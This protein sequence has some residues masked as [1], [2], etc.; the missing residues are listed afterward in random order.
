MSNE[1]R[2]VIF[3]MHLKTLHFFC[4]SESVFYAK[5]LHKAVKMKTVPSVIAM[6]NFPFWLQQDLCSIYQFWKQPASTSCSLIFAVKENS[7]IHSRFHTNFLCT[8]LTKTKQYFLTNQIVKMT[9]FDQNQNTT[10]NF[11]NFLYF[12]LNFI[13]YL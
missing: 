9:Q 10:R 1:Q 7:F 4:E 8:F 6:L 3:W 12:C 5:F 11:L 13:T 2:N